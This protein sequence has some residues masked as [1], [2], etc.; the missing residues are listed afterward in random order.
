MENGQAYQWPEKVRIIFYYSC[1]CIIRVKNPQGKYLAKRWISFCG[2]K[3]AK[4][5]FLNAKQFFC[6]TVLNVIDCGKKNSISFKIVLIWS[7]LGFT[8]YGFYLH[9]THQSNTVKLNFL[10][11]I[12]SNHNISTPGA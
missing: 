11:F 8:K 7:F 2:K 9:P 5:H 10:V 1:P 3:E 12:F 6:Q 4:I